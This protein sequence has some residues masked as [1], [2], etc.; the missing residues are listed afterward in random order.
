MAKP[1][2]T[3]ESEVYHRTRSALGEDV[4]AVK[5]ARY[6]ADRSRHG[7]VPDVGSLTS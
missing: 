7:P 4:G 5:R 3:N 2:F 1:H 6:L